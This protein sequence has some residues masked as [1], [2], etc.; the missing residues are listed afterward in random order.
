L[1]RPRN[2]I[3]TKEDPS[4]G[5]LRGSLFREIMQLREQEDLV[6]TGP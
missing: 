1:A 3:T 5:R 4:F 6:E 2:Q